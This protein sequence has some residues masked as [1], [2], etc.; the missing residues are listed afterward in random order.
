LEASLFHP[1]QPQPDPKISCYAQNY[2]KRERTLDS[3]RLGTHFLLERVKRSEV[4]VDLVS[5]LASWLATSIWRHV[6][7]ENG[8]IDMPTTVE[9]DSLGDL[10]Q[11]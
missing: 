2:I 11:Y 8:V 7:P 4:V 6:R 10:T 5:E 1:S 9:V 3:R